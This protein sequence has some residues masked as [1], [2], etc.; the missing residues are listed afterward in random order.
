MPGKKIKPKLSLRDFLDE[1]RLA[2]FMGWEF[3]E[4]LKKV[5][6]YQSSGKWENVERPK[7]IGNRFVELRSALLE[8]WGKSKHNQ[9]KRPQTHAQFVA[10]CVRENGKG[11]AKKGSDLDDGF[12]FA[13]PGKLIVAVISWDQFVLR[14]AREEFGMSSAS[15][16]EVRQLCLETRPAI[17]SKNE[18]PWNEDAQH[19]NA[20]E[21]PSFRAASKP[22]KRQIQIAVEADAIPAI[23]PDLRRTF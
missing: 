20:T 1:R 4:E 22:T 15:V 17:Y 9:F 7:G 5:T 6:T 2:D 16:Q 3:D 21:G 8:E 10:E 23:T 18:K 14:C 11:A 13:P 19:Y 12:R